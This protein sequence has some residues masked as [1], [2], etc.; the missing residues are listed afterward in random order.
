MSVNELFNKANRFFLKQNYFEGLKI[1]EQIWIKYPKNT[2][3]HEEI[4]KKIKRYNKSIPQTYSESDIKN[5]FNL[6][7]K[8]QV[9][10][11]IKTLTE[12]LKKNPRDVLTISLLGIFYNSIK[13]YEKAI[14]FHHTAIKKAPLER[15]F[16]LN[17]SETLQNKGEL[18]SS[19]KALYMAKILSLNDINIDYKIAKLQTKM[20]NF[21]NADLIYKV[22]IKEKNI[23]KKVIHSYC[24]NLIK[25]KK[26]NEVIQFIEDYEKKEI[27]DDNLKLLIGLA[28][29]NQKNFNKAIDCFSLALGL[30]PKNLNTL[31]MLGS[32]YEKIGDIQKAKQFYDDALKLDPNNKMTLN[33]FA[34][35]SFYNGEIVEAEKLYSHA[36]EKNPNNYE[37]MY[38][39]AQCQL[40]QLHFNEGWKNF[41]FR[42][43]AN[44]FNSPKLVSKLPE[45]DLNRDKKNLLVWTE[46]GLGDQILFL[47]FLRDL[48]PYIDNLFI[49]IDKRLHQIIKR[50]FPKINFINSNKEI[51]ESII[52]C[53]IPIGDLGSLFIKNAGNLKNT[54]KK[55]ITS[56]PVLSNQLQNT[57]RTKNKRICGLSWVSKNDD[58]GS[59]K[60][61]TLEMLKPIL[62][63]KDIIFIDLQYN[64]T[65]DERNKFL[66]NHGIKIHKIES[67]DSFNDLNGVTSLIDACDFIITVSNTNAHIAGALGKKTFLLLP[68]GKGRLWYWTFK[69]NQSLW[70]DSIKIVQQKILGKWDEPIKSLIKFIRRS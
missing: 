30:N 9:S 8:G 47:R 52:N 13:D 46:Q 32:S 66:I 41:K 48:E 45:F 53:Q 7:Q 31:N 4:S 69:N 57:L 24:D 27:S 56:D 54:S 36:I 15:S 50:T 23:S 12:N 29:F 39:I 60:S 26:E 25:F 62:E 49:K 55:Y 10:I 40:A 65:Q 16:Y 67:I 63:I 5:F 42:W 28:Y 37:A 21:A 59:S 58:I 14:S 3:L 11:V 68:R 22:L 44:Q 33:N 34:A 51:L 38:N 61:V 43:M 1:Y 70:Y 64:N 2:R 19:L 17:L 35:L 20:K 18:D 6:E